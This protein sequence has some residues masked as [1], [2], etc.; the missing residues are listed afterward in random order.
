MAFESK[1]TESVLLH[2]KPKN[3]QKENKGKTISQNVVIEVIFIRVR[4]NDYLSLIHI[5]EPTRPY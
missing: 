3:S 4:I 1:I 5:S 2:R